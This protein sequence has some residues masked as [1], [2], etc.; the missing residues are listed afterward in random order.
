MP[1]L[2][3]ENLAKSFGSLQVINSFFLHLE[4]GEALGIIGPNGAGKSTLF[5]LITGTL[6]SDQGVITYD[7]RDITRASAFDR[8]RAGISRSYQIPHPFGGMTVFENL[9]VGAAFGGG[10]GEAESTDHCAAILER[11]GLASKANALAGSLTLLERKRL[12]LARA[13]A[14]KPRVLLLDEIAGG[15]TE[16]EV[17]DLVATING[18]RAEN[19]SI[20]WIEHI[21]HAL[22]SVVDRLIVINFGEKLDDGDPEAVINSPEVQKVYMGISVE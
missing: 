14:T 9:L 3:V 1:L 16:P 15:L 20:I 10:D 13:L 17:V 2:D 8:C 5:N 6:S 12:E 11:T 19:M 18:I 4:E 22:L 7:G 21:V